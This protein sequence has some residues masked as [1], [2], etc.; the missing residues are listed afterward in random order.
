M[1][2]IDQRA[3]QALELSQNATSQAVQGQDLAHVAVDGMDNIKVS[4]DDLGQQTDEIGKI[5]AFIQE[6]AEQTNLL[7]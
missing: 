6:I 7:A 1:D 2:E 5:L 3:G 4:V